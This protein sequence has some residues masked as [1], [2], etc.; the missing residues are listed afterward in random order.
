[1]GRVFGKKPFVF[2]ARR[3]GV[4]DGEGI[5]EEAICVFGQKWLMSEVTKVRI[6]G[7]GA[8]WGNNPRLFLPN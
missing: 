2:L 3:A 1:M 5:W 8:N 7:D 4:T 6:G